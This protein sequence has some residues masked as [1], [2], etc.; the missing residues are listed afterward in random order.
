MWILP[1][2]LVFVPS[3]RGSYWGHCKV[4]ACRRELELCC[5]PGGLCHVCWGI[6]VGT[7]EHPCQWGRVI[8]EAAS[9]AAS[10]HS[11]QDRCTRIVFVH[12][13]PIFSLPVFL[14][15][16]KT[17]HTLCE[18]GILLIE[19]LYFNSFEPCFSPFEL[20]VPYE[21]CC[22]YNDCCYYLGIQS[23][24]IDVSAVMTMRNHFFQLRLSHI[25]AFLSFFFKWSDVAF[26]WPWPQRISEEGG[27]VRVHAIHAG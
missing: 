23:N 6:S 22:T 7:W 13:D 3:V 19:S 14:H 11:Q 9:E 26:M 8:R 20:H 4:C 27:V 5:D 2:R 16:S 10:R 17:L 1:V 21:R 12:K 18:L 24:Q 15:W 25:S